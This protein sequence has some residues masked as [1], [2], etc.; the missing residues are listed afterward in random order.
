MR[1]LINTY[2]RVPTPTN[3]RRLQAYITKYP[4]SWVLASET[5]REFLRANQFEFVL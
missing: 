1:K 2:R 3:R 5:Q 4:M